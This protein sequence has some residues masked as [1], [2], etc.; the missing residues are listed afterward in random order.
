MVSGFIEA[1]A[2]KDWEEGVAFA[3]GL[4]L[5]GGVAVTADSSNFGFLG[6]DTPSRLID[7][8]IPG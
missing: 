7:S 5:E 6:A 8:L 2:A 4:E 3:L 1:K